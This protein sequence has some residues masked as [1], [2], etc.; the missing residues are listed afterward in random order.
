MG[1]D[2]VPSATRG[3]AAKELAGY[4]RGYSADQ[5]TAARMAAAA[6]GD[7]GT[8]LRIHTREELG[9]DPDE[10]PLVTGRQVSGNGARAGAGRSTL[11][12]LGSCS[13]RVP[14]GVAFTS[15]SR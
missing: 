12:R 3:S 4:F 8:A 14:N 15:L 6:S 5:D 2:I 10:L 9:V 1:S 13:S 7:S 11:T